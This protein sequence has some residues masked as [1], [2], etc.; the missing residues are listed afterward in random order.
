MFH[1]WPREVSARLGGDKQLLASGLTGAVPDLPPD[2][3]VDVTSAP[4]A[5]TRT[6]AGVSHVCP[7]E[8][9]KTTAT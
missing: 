2:T 8:A 6:Y 5:L 3:S 4:H 9:R 1:S 7:T